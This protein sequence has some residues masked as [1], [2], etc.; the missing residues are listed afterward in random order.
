MNPRAKAKP[1]QYKVHIY[2]INSYAEITVVS[3]F[4]VSKKNI[5]LQK[6]KDQ[7]TPIRIYL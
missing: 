3:N 4:I 6:K 5:C 7:M 2:F 1:D